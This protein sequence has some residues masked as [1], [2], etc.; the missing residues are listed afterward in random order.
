M[1]SNME[2]KKSNKFLYVVIAL[3]SIAVILLGG[4]IVKDKFLDKK[5]T[6]VNDTS[7]KDKNEENDVDMND[8]YKID[9]NRAWIYDA[10]Y[11]K[12]V[13]AEQYSTGSD[14]YYA[15]SIVVPYININSTYATDSNNEIKKV[16]DMAIE[17]YNQGVKDE[18]TYVDECNYKKYLTDDVLSVLV[19]FGVGA[20]DVVQPNYYTYNFDLKTGEKLSYEDVYQL[21]GFNSNNIE[22][23]VTSAI[24]DVMKEK[25]SDMSDDNYP[26]GTNFDYYN[27]KSMMNYRDSVK[28][29]TLRYFL[30]ND[31]KLNVV[32]KLIIPAG[33]EE[34]DTIITVS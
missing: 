17:D 7:L 10:E 6:D 11:E 27:N 31:G 30:S 28:N 13:S 25:M 16:F 22:S 3:L 15:K 29:N 19:T 14:T 34:F 32:V 26:E 8:Y 20:T 4:Y 5:N 33:I 9:K 21:A 23:K 1:E 12:K 24:T 18:M 2:N